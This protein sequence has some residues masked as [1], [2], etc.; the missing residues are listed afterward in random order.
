VIE[1]GYKGR[2]LVLV[3]GGLVLFTGLGFRLAFLHLGPN[4]QLEGKVSRVRHSETTI[5]AERGRILD[6]RGNTLAMDLATHDVWVDPQVIRERDAETFISSHLA[7]ILQ[8]PYSNVL[9]RAS[10]EGRRYEPIRRRVH[11]DVAEQIRRMQM[12]GVHFDDVMQRY[13]PQGALMCHVL[14]FTNMEGVGSGGIE[15]YLNSALRGLPGLRVTEKD[16]RRTELYTRRYL[17][18][19]PRA[20]HQVELTLDQTLQ[21]IMEEA[22]DWGLEEF[23][24]KAAWAIMMRVNT[25][26]ILAM[27]SRPSYDLNAFRDSS[28]EER[29]NRAISYN[30]EPGSTFKVA[31][32]AAAFNEGLITEDMMID[33][34]QGQ[35]MFRGRPLRDYRPHGVLSVSD[36]LQKSSNIGSAKIAMMMPENQLETYLR[37]FGIGRATGIDL[38]G[39]EGGILAPR[40]QWSAISVSRIAMGHEV[41]VTSLQLLNA[42]NA[43]A[44]DGFLMEPY[45]IKRVTDSEGQ[46]LSEG[47]PRIVGQPIRQDTARLMARLMARV[48]D[49]GGTGRNARMEDF[50]V[51]GKT[52][53]AQKPIPG[54]Y[55]DRLNIASFVGFLPAE[56]PQVSMVV[57]VDE[58]LPLRTGGAVA[59]PIFKRIADSAVRYLDIPAAPALARQD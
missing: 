42:V 52:G 33:C 48:T 8:V 12:P 21:Y 10:R 25:G 57:V 3:G 4:E 13:Y 23:A 2:L 38:P 28:A 31:V 22:L 24:G 49:D 55:S 54:G 27:A 5:P 20:G 14:G 19:P 32:I 7:R 35:W 15:Q 59:A 46:V 47:E 18:I 37:N 45:V 9:D 56:N 6:A 50:R 41:A 51:A 36:V 29:R 53:T 40:S 11:R 17:D 30:Y 58:P 43:I 44:N 34:E 26:E 16:G 1:R 39:E